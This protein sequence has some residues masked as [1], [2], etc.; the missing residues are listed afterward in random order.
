MN[1]WNFNELTQQD[2]FDFK[3]CQRQDKTI[4][5][6]PDKSDCVQGKEISSDDLNKLARAANKG[7][8]KAKAQIEQYKKVTAEQ[9]DKE[10]AEKKKKKEAEAKKKA[11]A[12]A[13]GKKGK[14]GKGKK[15]GGK[16][17]KGGKGKGG[18][19]SA[20]GNSAQMSANAKKAQATAAQARQKR[21][22][23]IR[24][25]VSE[26]Q[27][28]IRTIKNPELRKMLE[29]QISDALRTVSDIQSKTPGG[30]AQPPTKPAEKA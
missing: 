19:A 27:K 1:N 24:A 7:D 9:A 17:K 25:R 5:G 2:Q 21:A 6:V 11:E 16:G 15:G 26:L 18:A 10:K 3:A 12:G 23:E 29:Q 28:T 20:K 13:K 30:D 22:K 4:Y 8:K 14:G